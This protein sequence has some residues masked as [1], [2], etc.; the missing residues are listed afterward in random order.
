MCVCVC[1][2]GGEGGKVGEG[3][4]KSEK[5]AGKKQLATRMLLFEYNSGASLAPLC[6]A[7]LNKKYD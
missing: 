1:V 5:R 4:G 7:Y 6:W 2:W 3:M